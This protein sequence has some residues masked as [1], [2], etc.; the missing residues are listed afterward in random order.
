M[1]LWKLTVMAALAAVGCREVPENSLSFDDVVYVED[2]CPPVIELAGGDTLSI[3]VL[4]VNDFVIE[5]SLLIVSNRDNSGRVTVLEMDGTVLGRFLR[6]GRGPGEIVDFP[7]VSFVHFSTAENGH[8]EATWSNYTGEVT[9][10]DVTASLQSGQSALVSRNLNLEDSPWLLDVLPLPDGEC[11][12]ILAGSDRNSIKRCVLS[13]D[14]NTKV[15]SPLERLN[16]AIVKKDTQS[17]TGMVAGSG[18][19][20]AFTVPGFNHISGNYAYEP[21][22]GL[23]IEAEK[24]RNTINIFSP[25]GGYARTVCTYGDSPDDISSIDGNTVDECMTMRPKAYQDFFTAL[26]WNMKAKEKRIRIYSYEGQALAEI[27]V[28]AGVSGYGFD[29][30]N[31]YLY[32]LDTDNECLVRYSY[33]LSK[34]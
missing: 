12:I 10:W 1:N 20:V 26:H 13:L 17:G 4:G 22:R 27:P 5:D 33:L 9:V 15:T 21:V 19:M 8:L 28:P 30:E 23:V 31:G 24:T 7:G 18:E 25:D 32:L 3:P 34:M 14:G 11:L 16:K 2:N 6:T 29:P